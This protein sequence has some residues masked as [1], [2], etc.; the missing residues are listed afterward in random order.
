[1]FGELLLAI[2]L[3]LIAYAFYK[4]STSTSRYF[5][6]RNVKHSGG[7]SAIRNLFQMFSGSFDSLEMSK[8]MYN[9]FPDE[10]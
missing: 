2:G 5:E 7:F 10:T 8:R 9:A 1:M 4:L 3:A 6:E